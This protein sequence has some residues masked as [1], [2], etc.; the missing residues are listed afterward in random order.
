MSWNPWFNHF[1][2]PPKNHNPM[3]RER[4]YWC[5]LLKFQDLDSF[6]LVTTPILL[7]HTP[8]CDSAS[9][10]RQISPEAEGAGGEDRRK[11]IAIGW[12]VSIPHT[13]IFYA[14]IHLYRY[15]C[16]YIIMYKNKYVYIYILLI[17]IYI[18]MYI[19]YIY[20]YIY[21]YII[22]IYIYIYISIYI[23]TYIYIYICRHIYT[24]M[25][26]YMFTYS[27]HIVFN[28][29]YICIVVLGMGTS[30]IL[31]NLNVSLL[32]LVDTLPKFLW[33]RWF[34]SGEPGKIPSPE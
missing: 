9:L 19:I 29:L 2:F 15:I 3:S 8:L 32:Q 33:S 30:S 10:S 17:Y 18:Y 13:F 4:V 20:I 22:R 14:Y 24:R 12:L 21:M 16:V 7:I 6:L 1:R 28:T 23:Y 27:I 31:R 11:P 26:D 5:L 34:L 25:I